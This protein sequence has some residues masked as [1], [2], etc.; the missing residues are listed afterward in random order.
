ME[1]TIAAAIG[2]GA[3]VG[4]MLGLIGGGGSILATPLLLYVVGISQAHVAIGISALAVSA[5]AYVNLLGHARKGNVW[6]SRAILFALVGAIGA[7]VGSTLGKSF[8]GHLLVV[9]FGGV[10]V[11]VGLLML[12]PQKTPTIAP[13]R[14]NGFRFDLRTA[15]TAL[16][17]GLVSGFFGIGGGFLIVPGFM[18]ATRMPMINA[19]GSSLLAVGTFGLATALNYAWSGLVDWSVAMEFVAGGAIGGILGTS[20]A[21]RMAV[22]KY[23]LNRLFAGVIFAVAFYL[24]HRNMFAFVRPN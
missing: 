19:V 11:V 15:I 6:W 8:D 12:C 20:A 9:L 24:I 17:V 21:T 23:A 7:L 10:M 13:Q 14:E 4:F 22:H 16:L 5:N 1:S 18:L 2:S 3:L